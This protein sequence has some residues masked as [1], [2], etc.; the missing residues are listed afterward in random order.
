MS[1]VF[2][3]RSIYDSRV[4]VDQPPAFVLPISTVTCVIS[5]RSLIRSST[6][7]KARKWTASGTHS[8]G[9]ISTMVRL[10][11]SPEG[12][13]SLMVTAVPLSGVGDVRRCTQ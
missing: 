10:Y 13:V 11:R 7:A 4:T 6:R 5:Y 8:E 1:A 12:A 2:G 9:K 3:A